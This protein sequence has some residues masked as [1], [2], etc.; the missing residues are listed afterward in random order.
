MIEVKYS[1]AVQ[2]LINTSAF[3][4]ATVE[5]SMSILKVK[6]LSKHAKIPSK[7]TKNSV[8]FIC[9]GNKLET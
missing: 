2:I 6:I 1:S 7:A 3:V 9:S 8:G 4:L 5:L